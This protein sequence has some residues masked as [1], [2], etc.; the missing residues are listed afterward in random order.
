MKA[1]WTEKQQLL[2]R[3]AKKIQPDAWSK[4]P[5]GAALLWGTLAPLFRNFID[6]LAGIASTS[7][8]FKIKV[9]RASMTFQRT[10][11]CLNAYLPCCSDTL[12]TPKI[13][14]VVHTS[15][16]VLGAHGF[17]CYSPSFK[18]GR[19]CKCVVWRSYTRGIKIS[20]HFHQRGPRKVLLNKVL[21]S[22]PLTLNLQLDSFVEGIGVIS[23]FVVVWNIYQEMFWKFASRAFGCGGVSNPS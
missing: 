13:C 3:S 23:W 19:R 6:D 11:L 17:S 2:L 18:A 20:W 21:P 12:E 22:C 7:F 4:I 8:I 5:T 15:L 10:V 14:A 1:I 16:L 9:S